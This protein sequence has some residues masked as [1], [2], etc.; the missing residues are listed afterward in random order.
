MVAEYQ[1]AQNKYYYYT[2]DQISST[3]VV[4]DDSGNVVYAAMYDP[5]GGLPHTRA[6]AFD[7]VWKFSGKEQD[8]ESGLY[9]FGA[10]Y[11]DPTLYRFLS[12]DPVIT[13]DRAI[14][15]PRRWN[16]YGYCL[17][18]PI[19]NMDVNGYW[20]KRVHYDI[21]LKAMLIPF[22]DWPPPVARALAETVANACVNMDVDPGTWTI[23][24]FN[25]V[26]GELIH[27]PSEEQIKN[28]HFPDNDRLMEMIHLA[29]T[30]LEPR[31]FGKA[32][33]VIQDFFAPYEY[34]SNHV[35]DTALG[36][37]AKYFPEL[38]LKC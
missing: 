8:A 24:C 34:D 21:T 4:T 5:Y 3:R 19:N 11:Y 23:P 6:N 1:P 2:T 17:N 25:C 30:T 28:W 29:E 31:E 12:P 27:W 35:Y 16:L 33:H 32:L 36:W 15:N 18:D 37:V 9:Y 22:S 7:P 14:F 10:R 13:T 38:G 20:S 26:E